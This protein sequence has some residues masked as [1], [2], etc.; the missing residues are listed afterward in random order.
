MICLDHPLAIKVDLLLC[1]Q[2]MIGNT[3]VVANIVESRKI[4]SWLIV[5]SSSVILDS[6]LRILVYIRQGQINIVR[7]VSHNRTTIKLFRRRHEVSDI[8]FRIR[9]IPYGFSTTYSKS[10]LSLIRRH[11]FRIMVDINFMLRMEISHH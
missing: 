9:I 6:S 5:F 11:L 8:S 7:S 3:K 2:P 10:Q 1:N 4:R